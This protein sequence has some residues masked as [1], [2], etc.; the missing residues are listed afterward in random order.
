MNNDVMLTNLMTAVQFV[1]APTG[2][3]L[4]VMDAEDWIDL[5]E[6]LEEAEDR[7]I[8]RANL[9]RLRVGPEA[10]GALLLEA[11]LDEL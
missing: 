6:W 3:R 10:S 9:E 2:R 8:I 4:A 5:M 7:Q 1:Q 11:V